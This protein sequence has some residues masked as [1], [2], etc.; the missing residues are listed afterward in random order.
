MS[1]YKKKLQDQRW[2]DKRKEILS[3][4]K[5]RC[6]RKNCTHDNNDL[7]VHHTEYLPGI[8]PWDYPNDMLITLCR[9]HH[10]QET[11]RRQVESQLFTTLKMKGF[12]ISD[13]LCFSTKL[14]KDEEFTTSLL[15]TLRQ[16]QN[17]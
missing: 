4:D 14:R 3:R 1:T 16:E 6:Q 2:L 8:D 13:L 7:Q 9:F 17:G 12:F 11:F 10:Q 5:S 15:N